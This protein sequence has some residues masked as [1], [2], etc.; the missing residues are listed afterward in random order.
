M[1]AKSFQTHFKIINFS[2]AFVLFL[3][4]ISNLPH[5]QVPFSALVNYSLYFFVFLQCC[6]ILKRA[7]KNKA[8][9][10]NIGLLC[11]F[12]S[13]GFINLFLGDGYLIGNDYLSFYFFQYRKILFSFLL[14]LSII[15]VLVSYIFSN[16]RTA[17]IYFIS[18]LV[19]LPV[20]LW[21]F[22]Q[23]IIDKDFLLNFQDNVLLYKSI[24]Y[25]TFFSFL[26]VCLYGF[27]LYRNE[28]SLGEHINSL[29]VCFF[30]LTLI[31]ITDTFAYIYEIKLFSISQYI[32]LPTLSFFIITLFRKLNYIYSDFGQFYDTLMTEG[33]KWGVPI[34]RKKSAYALSFLSLVQA[35]LH[36]KR[37]VFGLA[38]LSLVFC[39][40]Y[41]D[42]SPFLK[43]HLIALVAGMIVL[44]FYL[45]ALYH[46]RLSNGD[47]LSLH[48][49]KH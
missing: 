20:L 12:Y 42:V 21:H 41:F 23:F 16:L 39:V 48:R 7:Q 34:K 15:Y 3:A 26:G 10:F 35:Y 22:G 17:Q 28:I 38:T 37:N 25:F 9:F 1:I 29:M 2:L 30:V 27:F 33:N 8:I 4:L 13:L 31:D 24:L 44:F 11:F 6:F 32:A 46:K 43:L 19:T 47:L 14:G 18:L 49:D 40:S 36:Q 45:S 5:L